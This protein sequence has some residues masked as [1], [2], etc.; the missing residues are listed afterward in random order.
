VAIDKLS[1]GHE[2]PRTPSK[3]ALDIHSRMFEKDGEKCHWYHWN[4]FAILNS[5]KNHVRIFFEKENAFVK[6]NLNSIEE[7]LPNKFFSRQS[8]IYCELTCNHQH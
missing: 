3:P 4:R 7:R 2:E 1:I 6:K 8:S 5:C